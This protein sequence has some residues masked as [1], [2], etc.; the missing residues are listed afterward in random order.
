MSD[1]LGALIGGTL[2]GGF[3]LLSSATQY[4]QQKKLDS[5]AYERQVELVKMQQA[6]AE[7]MANTAHQREVEDLRAAGLNPILS[8]TGGNGAMTPATSASGVSTGSTAPGL[9]DSPGFDMDV[10]NTASTIGLNKSLASKAASDAELAKQQLQTEKATQADIRARTAKT[11]QETI[12]LRHREQ[13]EGLKGDAAK[14]VRGVLGAAADLFSSAKSRRE[15]ADGLKEMFLDD[16][17]TFISPGGKLLKEAYHGLT[18]DIPATPRS[19][20]RDGV[21]RLKR[22]AGKIIWNTLFK[23]KKNK[24]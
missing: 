6:W 12:N 20:L 7:R 8:A 19:R 13:A 21:K 22:G 23:R 5:K 24:R 3:G 18:G 2:Q 4:N 1:W 11:R 14:N 9:G 10:L 16:P 15:T 17:M